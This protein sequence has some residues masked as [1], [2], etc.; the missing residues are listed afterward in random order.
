MSLEPR[1]PKFPNYDKN[2]KTRRT[3]PAKMALL[4]NTASPHQIDA[5]EHNAIFFTGGHASEYN[6]PDS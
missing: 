4:E 3:D 1:A 6:F 2:A 5:C